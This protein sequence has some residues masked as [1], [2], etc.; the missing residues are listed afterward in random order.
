[1]NSLIAN[2]FDENLDDWFNVILDNTIVN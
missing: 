2:L 1:V